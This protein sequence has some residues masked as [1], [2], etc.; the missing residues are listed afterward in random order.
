VLELRSITSRL[1]TA[2]FGPLPDGKLID[3]DHNG[4]NEDAMEAWDR[5]ALLHG[6]CNAVNRRLTANQIS[7][8]KLAP[9]QGF[10]P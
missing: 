7:Y 2:S 8:S 6:C 4:D 3:R 10:E 5:D 9:G 1:L